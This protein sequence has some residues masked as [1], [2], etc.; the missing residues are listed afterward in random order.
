M[1]KGN[2]GQN[3]LINPVVERFCSRTCPASLVPGSAPPGRAAWAGVYPKGAAL[4]PHRPG[5]QLG[6]PPSAALLGPS[7][8][9]LLPQQAFN[10]SYAQRKGLL[11]ARHQLT[12]DEALS[13]LVGSKRQCKYF[14]MDFEVIPWLRPHLEVVG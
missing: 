1:G 4:P 6:R 13:A 5:A 11:D 12:P 3:E 9:A 8:P 14:G 10:P 7:P 2:N